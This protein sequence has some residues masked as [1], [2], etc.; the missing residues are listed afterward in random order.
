M[1][2]IWSILAHQLTN[3]AQ[4][5]CEAASGVL[6][7]VVED[8]VRKC[9]P[10]KSIHVNRTDIEPV[11]PKLWGFNGNSDE[12]DCWFIATFRSY[13]SADGDCWGGAADSEGSCASVKVQTKKGSVPDVVM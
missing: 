13:K 5:T 3:R 9:R 8:A 4:V 10:F 6:F 1:A 2:R 11:L 12:T 7:L